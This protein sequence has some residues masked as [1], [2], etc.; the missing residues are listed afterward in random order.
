[1][2]D[3]ADPKRPTSESERRLGLLADAMPVCVALTSADLRYTYVN[4][5]YEQWFARSREE[6]VGKTGRDI[7]GESAW[8]HVEPLLR[9]ALTGEHVSYEYRLRHPDG[10]E[11]DV[12]VRVVPALDANGRVEGLYILTEDI[13][14]RRLAEG[15]LHRTTRSYK[16]LSRCLRVLVRATDEID[17]ARSVCR[18]IVEEAG[19]RLAWVGYAE[20]DEARTVRPV[21]QAGYEAG[22]LET[23]HVTWADTERGRGPTGT[24]VREGRPSVFQNVVTNPAF[25]PWR[26]A[27]LERGYASVI[28]LPLSVGG[29][30]IGA[31]TIYAPEPDAFDAEEADLLE[32][33]A[34]DLSYGIEALRTRTARDRQETELR[35]AS[36]FSRQIID[37]AREGVAVGDR[38]LKIVVWNRF[39]E[40]I[41]G[42]AAAEVLGRTPQE[43]FPFVRE[44]RLDDL[45]RRA[46][47]GEVV[48]TGDYPFQVPQTGKSGWATQQLV[49]LRNAEGE[50]IGVIGTLHDITERKKAEEERARLEAQVQHAQKLESLGI[51]AGG[52]AHDFNNLLTS[53]LGY[54]DLA[55]LQLSRVSPARE[56]VERIETA[57]ARAA[58]LTRQ[59][60]AYSGRGQFVVEPVMVPE[61]IEEM[62]HLLE[63]SISRK[64]EIRYTFDKGLPAVEADVTQ[65]RQVIMNVVINASEAIGDQGGVIALGVSA[66]H[67][68]RAF[69]SECYLGETLPEGIYV[70]LDV[71]DTGCGMTEDVKMK[72]F[73]PFFSTKFTGRGLGL[74]AALGIVRGHKGAI[75]VVSAPGRGT[76]FTILF[77]A[78]PRSAREA[79]TPAGSAETLR[80]GGTILVVDDEEMV[81]GLVKAMLEVLG[82][83]VLTA[84]DG[85]EGVELFKMHAPAI[86][87]VLLDLT[88]PR[89]DGEATFHELRAVRGDVR[90]VLSSGYN[91]QDA[92]SRFAGKGLAGFIQKPYRLR[93]L[94]DVLVQILEAGPAGPPL[95]V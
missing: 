89:M 14:A 25:A 11:R 3:P 67:R 63:V 5:T 64:C 69:L 13:T 26:E 27:A 88:M 39:M 21:A 90:V 7:L 36:E 71:A 83:K 45:S 43:L 2:D 85:I 24:S 31:V 77:P 53:I 60:L 15:R 68:D 54:A 23:V 38:D 49:P 62:T 17:L 9:R 41:S 75:R 37:S 1:M 35:E 92:T 91:R 59:L 34:A 82:F 40:E 57:A 87:A 86:R 42:L 18:A 33:L 55:L 78:S 47:E 19:F 74:A 8:R 51:M 84:S 44:Q 80:G 81:R 93:E 95:P 56:N 16:V 6:I 48:S 30:T 70:S 52:I 12:F 10:V 79:G 66:H 32:E 28:G 76:T 46:L 50:I 22:Y 20:D 29:K 72:L 65:L 73:D 58:D 4:R 61:V 94:K